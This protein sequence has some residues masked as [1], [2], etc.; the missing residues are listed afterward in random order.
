MNTDVASKTGQ[1]GR[2]T[3]TIPNLKGHRFDPSHG[4]RTFMN[5]HVC[6][7]SGL[8]G[9]SE[10]TF[11]DVALDENVS[12]AHNVCTLQLTHGA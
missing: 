11:L 9:N 1:Q 6:G 12:S 7:V 10:L 5:S 3:E 8:E 2:L 4:Q